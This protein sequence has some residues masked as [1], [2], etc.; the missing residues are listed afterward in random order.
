[1][2]RL[3]S[4]GLAILAVGAVPEFSSAADN[5]PPE[6]F[7]ALFNGEDLSGWKGL[8]GNPKTRATMTPEDLAAAQ[9]KADAAM[10]E[11]WKVEDG[12]LVFDGSLRTQLTQLRASLTKGH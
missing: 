5:T 11:H 6:G 8:V 7:V 1:M 3:L 4:I 9:E 2:R 10:R 12:A